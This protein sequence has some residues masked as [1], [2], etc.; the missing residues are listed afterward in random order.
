MQDNLNPI[1]VFIA[2]FSLASVA[3]ISSLVRSGKELTVRTILAAGCYSGLLGLV[4]GLLWYN[5]FAP[6]NIF[7]LIGVSCLA[8]LGGV[9]LIDVIVQVIARGGVNILIQP[10]D[11]KND[12]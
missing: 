8:G 7:F 3:G 6:A 9:S 12:D 4:I 10:K 5:Y 1:H 2:C 11:K